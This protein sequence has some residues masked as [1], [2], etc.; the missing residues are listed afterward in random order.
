MPSFD[1]VSEVDMHE[2]S[3]AVDQANREVSTRFD[4]KGTDARFE[5]KD[6]VVT[7]HA[8]VEFQLE[9]MLDMLRNKL[10]RRGVDV[11]CIK[12]EDVE[13]AGQRARQ[14]VILRQGIDQTLAKK[15]VKLIKDSKLKTQAAIQGEKVRV[16]GKKRDDLQAI[17]AVLK[18]AKLEMPLQYENFRD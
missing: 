16:S 9:Q 7:M 5:L 15:I 1:V 8:Q 3:N 10:A 14:N 6:S 4:F 2:V 17:I 13:V 18:D 11:A 12:L